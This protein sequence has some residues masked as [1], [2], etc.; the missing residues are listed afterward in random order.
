MSKNQ[1]IA[2][3]LGLEFIPTPKWKPD[4][5]NYILQQYDLFTYN[6]RTKFYFDND[7]DNNIINNNNIY[8]P[9]N[10]IPIINKQTTWIPPKASRGIENYLETVKNR[11]ER[12]LS[13]LKHKRYKTINLAP[14]SWLIHALKE[15]KTN[16]EIII[17][18]ADKNMGIVVIKTIDYIKEGLSQLNNTYTYTKLET[19]PDLSI[20]WNKLR[21]I[22]SKYNRLYYTRFNKQEVSTLAKTLLQ[23]EN[24]DQN[25]KFS[26]FYLLMK[27]HKTPIK[28]RPIVSSINSMTYFTSIY[29]DKCLQP[30]LKYIPT[31]IQSS[32]ELIHYIEKQT[33]EKD[34]FILCADIDSLYPNIPIKEGL[35]FFKE[36][37][38]YHKTNHPQEFHYLNIDFVCDLMDWVLNHNYFTF[39]PLYYHQKNGTAMGTPAAVVFACLFI[40]SLERKIKNNVTF[41]IPLMRRYID[42]I[43]G[44]FTTEED[45]RTYINLFNS[46]LPTIH[47]SS[48]T[49]SK[50]NGIF[51][52][53]EIFKGS[54]FHETSVFDIKLYQKP[55][56]KY[57]YLPPNSFHPK[58]VFKAFISAEI[59]RYRLCCNNDS[60]FEKIKKQFYLR[61]IARGYED[62]FL[63]T[64]FNIPTNR[65][66]IL[67]K[68][69]KR[70]NNANIIK[71]VQRQE[72]PVLFKTQHC[73]QSIL[74]DL[75]NC[76]KLND[77]AKL[78]RFATSF[79]NDRNPIKCYSNPPSIG[80]FFRKNRKNLHNITIENI[81]KINEDFTQNNLL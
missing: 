57:L 44:I 12:N 68:I 60:D 49:I 17:T 23:L 29:I 77:A 18:N 47:C 43:F 48:Y 11:I 19:A 56:N 39:G 40:D 59:N 58:A 35:T 80:T 10:H 51:L 26:T 30:M 55:Q 53:L 54:R 20:G 31:Y 61:L 2:L 45:A 81:D 64:I 8:K 74:L 75:S 73:P 3:S 36:A 63:Q 6:I 34:C 32:Q 69:A 65:N 50:Q 7:N 27:V 38:D 70:M 13:N 22:L 78:E 62:N 71:K 66:C 67:E 1:T 9:E 24:D 21:E 76:L 79:F 16:K 41:E 33:F 28:G 14:P 37:L 25:L 5:N 46:E 72:V 52:D 42:D 4:F 15:I